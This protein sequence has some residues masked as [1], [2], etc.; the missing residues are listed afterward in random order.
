ML[1]GRGVPSDSHMATKKTAETLTEQ[2]PQ[3]KKKRYFDSTFGILNQQG[4]NPRCNTQTHRHKDR[5]RG[6]VGGSKID[7]N[8][9]LLGH[10]ELSSKNGKGSNN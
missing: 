4:G 10:D 1:T 5:S 3:S 9:S 7:A 6:S 8:S 2:F